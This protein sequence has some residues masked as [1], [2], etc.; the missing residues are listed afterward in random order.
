MNR[1]F[2]AFTILLV[3][4]FALSGCA[5]S[6][7]QDTWD[8][9]TGEEEINL[10][11]VNY[12]AADM[13]GQQIKKRMS[14]R[15]T[16]GAAPLQPMT[17]KEG[18][19]AIQTLVI[20]QVA[21]RLTQIGINIT[22]AAPSQQPRYLLTGHYNETFDK[23]DISLRVLDMEKNQIIGTH[24]YM[25]P[26]NSEIRELLKPIKGKNPSDMP[27]VSSARPLPVEQQELPE[28]SMQSASGGQYIN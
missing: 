18:T 3:S 21:S 7:V 25:L 28:N 10:T 4:L 24:D 26:M 13:L 12:A 1:H 8:S 27:A 19:A 20:H 14:W 9:V 16:M 23:V 17:P 6:F 5:T 22:D 11:A 15:G 2:A